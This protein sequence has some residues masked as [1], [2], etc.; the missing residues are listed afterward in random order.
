MSAHSP[1][2]SFDNTFPESLYMHIHLFRHEELD[3]SNPS[4]HVR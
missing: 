1:T 2:G 4:L 3:H